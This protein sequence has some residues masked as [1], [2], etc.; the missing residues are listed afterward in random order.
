M[1]RAALDS[2]SPPH[3]D[4]LGPVHGGGLIPSRVADGLGLPLATA[5]TPI[6]PVLRALRAGLIERG[7]DARS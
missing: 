7:L 1:V 6:F 5:R 3:R 2:L 4:V